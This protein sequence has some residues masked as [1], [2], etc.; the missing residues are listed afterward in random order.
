LWNKRQETRRKRDTG[1][2]CEDYTGWCCT[3]LRPVKSGWR[4]A[5][6]HKKTPPDHQQALL[7]FAA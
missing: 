6:G 3:A 5:G 2:C 7:Q 1:R 4:A